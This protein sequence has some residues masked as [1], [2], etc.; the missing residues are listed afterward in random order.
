M[1]Q[2]STPEPSVLCV[3]E[4]SSG[5]ENEV[6]RV[7]FIWP[8]FVSFWGRECFI[9]FMVSYQDE[10]SRI[11]YVVYSTSKARRRLKVLKD[12][13]LESGKGMDIL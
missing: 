12:Y 9:M 5:V 11:R 4:K 10:D 7:Y 1:K 8:A 2:F 13:L 3:N 6:K